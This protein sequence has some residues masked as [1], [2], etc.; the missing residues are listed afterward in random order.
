MVS[1]SMLLLTSREVNEGLLLVHSKVSAIVLGMYAVKLAGSP[2]REASFWRERRRVGLSMSRDV[3][4]LSMRKASGAKNNFR[5]T[6]CWSHCAEDWDLM[7][8]VLDT[9]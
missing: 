2:R 4:Q 7:C 3:M 1:L 9:L 5:L 8:R 6:P